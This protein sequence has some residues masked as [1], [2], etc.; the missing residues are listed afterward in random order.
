MKL[1][2]WKRFTWDLKQL[3]LPAPKLD[4]RYTVRPAF[5]EDRKAVTAILLSAFSLDSAW[6]DIGAGLRDWLSSQIDIAFDREAAPAIVI[7]H[8][9]RIIAASAINTDVD[10]ETHLVT[11]PC[12]S[13]EYRSRGLGTA[14]LYHTLAHL[15]QSGLAIAHGVTKDNV[16]ATKF[17]YPKFGAVAVDYEFDPT[18]ARA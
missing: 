8:G 6:S 5:A 1:V 7:T 16:A 9:Q 10:A 2:R 3:P 12:V 15:R 17:V 4:E 11:G 14:L 18:P 13:M